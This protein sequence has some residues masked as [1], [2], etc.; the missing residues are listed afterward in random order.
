MRHKPKTN[1]KLEIFRILDQNF[2]IGKIVTTGHLVKLCKP[3]LEI[4]PVKNLG[5][6][7]VRN[8]SNLET[9]EYLE[10]LERGKY[11]I[12]KRPLPEVSDFRNSK[13]WRDTYT[14]LLHYQDKI[15]EFHFESTVPDMKDRESLRLDFRIVLERPNF[16]GYREIWIEANGR[17]H[18][19]P[20]KRFKGWRGFLNL[21]KKF[22]IKMDFAIR[23]DVLLIITEEGRNYQHIKKSIGFMLRRKWTGNLLEYCLNKGFNYWSKEFKTPWED[24]LPIYSI[25]KGNI[26]VKKIIVVK[27][28]DDLETW[29][30]RGYGI[31]VIA[32]IK[33]RFTGDINLRKRELLEWAGDIPVTIL[34]L[35]GSGR[36]FLRQ[37]EGL[38]DVEGLYPRCKRIKY[39]NS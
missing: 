30:R 7:V 34:A 6:V 38:I 10:R 13:I 16:L 31:I 24:P 12:I 21:S 27:Y 3:I 32:K 20:T 5:G 28:G 8:L 23:N 11:M 39:M 36:N 29:H 18:L 4:L 14:A 2:T 22:K 17:Q 9:R 1:W 15:R 26:N 25:Y 35:W 19:E 37:R 33:T